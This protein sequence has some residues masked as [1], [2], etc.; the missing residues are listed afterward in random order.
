M[1]H[2]GGYNPYAPKKKSRGCLIWSIILGVSLLCIAAALLLA[3][4]LL[5]ALGIFGRDAKEVY[6]QSPDVV[7][8]EKLSQAFS[9]RNIPGVEVYV[10]PI[11]GEPT[12]GAF[13]ILDASKGYTGLSPLEDSSDVFVELLRDL[14]RRNRDENLRISHVTVEYRDEE[15]SSML[16]FT[17]SQAD[18]EKYANGQISQDEFFK[19]VHFNLVDTLRKMGVEE[20]L[21]EYQP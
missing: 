5:R 10:I 7:A 14:T 13:I 17:V 8:S 18:V 4:M 11:K 9:E 2:P 6:E 1:N 19:A 21:E 3:P 12:Q 15:G 20:L 16:S